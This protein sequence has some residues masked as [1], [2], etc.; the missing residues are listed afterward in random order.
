MRDHARLREEGMNA[1]VVQREAAL[2]ETHKALDERDKAI[3]ECDE[4][5]VILAA[6]GGL[7]RMR[8]GGMYDRFRA[9]KETLSK[10]RYEAAKERDTANKE[11]DDAREELA[12]LRRKLDSPASP[13]FPDPTPSTGEDVRE[14]FVSSIKETL[15]NDMQASLTAPP[16]ELTSTKAA[17]GNPEDLLGAVTSLL[18]ERDNLV[19]GM[20]E[21]ASIKEALGNPEEVL[22]VIASLLYERVNHAA[23]EVQNK[24]IASILPYAHSAPLYDRIVQLVVM[25]DRFR[26]EKNAIAAVIV[27]LKRDHREAILTKNAAILAMEEEAREAASTYHSAREKLFEQIAALRHPLPPSF[28]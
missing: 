7:A 6:S 24:A 25:H 5:R 28:T 21:I 3:K 2:A 1:A 18:Y 17:L 19:K 27:V 15:L 8:E 9:E 23:Q 4:G 13:P 11:R 20:D 26:S 10:E 16:D 22:G 14:L 12:V